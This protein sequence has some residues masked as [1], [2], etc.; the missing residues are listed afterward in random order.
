MAHANQLVAYIVVWSACG[1]CLA[2]GSALLVA[3][4]LRTLRR[5]RSSRRS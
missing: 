4:T 2:C 5:A 3:C 1:V